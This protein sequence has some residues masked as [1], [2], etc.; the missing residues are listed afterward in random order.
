MAVE[1][2]LLQET[3]KDTS[4]I[5]LKNNDDLEVSK[6]AGIENLEKPQAEIISTKLASGNKQMMSNPGIIRVR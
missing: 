3:Y 6:Q 1:P 2:E 4:N 5:E